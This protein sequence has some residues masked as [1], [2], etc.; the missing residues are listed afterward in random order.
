MEI[1]GYQ[2]V[3]KTFW[4]RFRLLS[5]DPETLEEAPVDSAEAAYVEVVRDDGTRLAQKTLGDGLVNLGGG[6]YSAHFLPDTEG[7]H[8]V[9]VVAQIAGGFQAR[10]IGELV[11]YKG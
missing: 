6:W 10:D 9:R 4:V 5:V 11:I 1:V 8:L 3:G 7:E 2:R